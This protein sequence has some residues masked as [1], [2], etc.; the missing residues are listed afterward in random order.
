MITH[1]H[2]EV[3]G[4]YLSDQSFLYALCKKAKKNQA[5]LRLY[6]LKSVC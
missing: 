4:L 2:Q 5:G 1:E 3:Q 6:N